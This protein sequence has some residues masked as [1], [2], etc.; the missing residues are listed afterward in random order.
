MQQQQPLPT[1]SEHNQA[2]LHSTATYYTESTVGKQWLQQTRAC[3]CVTFAKENRKSI[4][5]FSPLNKNK[6]F[7]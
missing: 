4:H 6:Q 3:H 5:Q 1:A 2:E 7:C